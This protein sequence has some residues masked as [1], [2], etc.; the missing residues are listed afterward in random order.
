MESYN[1]SKSEVFKNGFTTI[2]NVFTEDQVEQIIKVIDATDGSRDTFRKSTDLFA[3]RQFLNEVPEVKPLVFNETFKF[4]LEELIGADFFVIK[5]IYFDK[6][7]RSNW[8]VPYHQ[9]LTISVNRKAELES[10][11]NWTVKQGQFSVQPPIEILENIYTF[12][13]HLDDT[14]EN[15]GALKVIPGS[16]LDGVFRPDK[17]DWDVVEEKTCKVSRGGL[18]IMKP[19]LLHSSSR[20]T[21]EN[22]RRVIHVEFCNRLLIK[23]LDWAEKLKLEVDETNNRS[24]GA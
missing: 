16:H 22:R 6:P 18:M 8:F 5:S 2:Q 14:N 12:R 23:E 24:G 3:I 13:V 15:N 17:I 7:A 1:Q 21:N 10:Y 11:Q 19:L 4:L 20:T 9:D